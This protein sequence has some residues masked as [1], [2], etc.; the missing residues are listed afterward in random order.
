MG[1]WT[2]APIPRRD[3]HRPY[4]LFIAP[5]AQAVA[6]GECER[7][8]VLGG[9]GNGEA[10]AANKSGRHPLPPSAGPSRPRASAGCTTTP[11]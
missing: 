7:G 6:S 3:P 11:T 10:I 5:A 1:L 8:I 4:P 2:L 9:S